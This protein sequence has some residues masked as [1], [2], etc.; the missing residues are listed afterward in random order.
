MLDIATQKN[1]QNQIFVIKLKGNIDALSASEFEDF[2]SSLLKRNNRFFILMATNLESL[3]SAGISA[4]VRFSKKIAK[5]N[6]AAAFVG[7]GSEIELLLDFFALNQDLPSFQNTESALV[8]LNKK[9]QNHPVSFE[10]EKEMALSHNLKSQSQKTVQLKNQSKSLYN[11]K[12]PEAVARPVEYPMTN[13]A[14]KTDSQTKDTRKNPL[15][16]QHQNSDIHS[17]ESRSSSVKTNNQPDLHN[18]YSPDNH[19]MDF[20]LPARNDLDPGGFN[21]TSI[22]GHYLRSS[23]VKHCHVCDLKLRFYRT[24]NHLCPG[25]GSKIE[26]HGNSRK[27]SGKEHI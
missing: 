13:M 16:N 11:K 23:L 5:L 1:I 25:C 19:S 4:L 14:Q 9:I 8:W 7:L 6:G 3:S 22:P 24:G 10:I 15:E 26:I 2:F 17:L 27:Q 20:F 18:Q 12:I 21:S